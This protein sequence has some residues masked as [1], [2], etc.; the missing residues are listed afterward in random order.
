MDVIIEALEVHK[1]IND[2]LKL[3]IRNPKDVDPS[4]IK[5]DRLCEF[6]VWIYGAGGARYG[7]SMEFKALRHTHQAF[8]HAAY[9]ALCQ[10]KVGKR[11]EAELSIASG[12]FNRLS[13][14]MIV[15][16]LAMQKVV[17]ADKRRLACDAVTAAG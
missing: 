12:G 1:R 15:R 2:R 7:G 8:H 3:A 4:S 9:H 14:E 6:G 17:E 16:L 13:E 11:E 5:T 10:C